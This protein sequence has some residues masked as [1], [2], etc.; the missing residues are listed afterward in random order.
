MWGH[1][2]EERLID[3]LNGSALAAA[4]AHVESCAR[5]REHLESARLGLGLAREADLI[6]EPSPL[7]WEEFRSQVERRIVGGAGA[8]GWR[9]R[10]AFAAAAAAVTL[11]ALLPS[12]RVEREAAGPEPQAGWSAL[13]PVAED[14]NLALLQELDAAEEE[15]AA[16]SLRHGITGVVAELSEAERQQLAEALRAELSGKKS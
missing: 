1:V 6:P 10:P 7:Y 16:V 12:S 13:A 3:V 11:L 2:S 14:A 9:L 4:V 8:W 15:V 5:C